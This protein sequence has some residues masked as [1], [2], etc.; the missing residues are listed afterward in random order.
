[1][2]YKIKIP[3]GFEIK[4]LMHINRL[5]FR[6]VREEF[7]DKPNNDLHELLPKLKREIENQELLGKRILCYWPQFKRFYKGVV[8]SYDEDTRKHVIH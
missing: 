7:P 3:R 4:T 8:Q 5:K 2:L 6:K 1:V